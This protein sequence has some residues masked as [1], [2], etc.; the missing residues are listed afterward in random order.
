MSIL[1]P[2]RFVKIFALAPAL[3]A[4]I[5]A[6]LVGQSL[7]VGGAAPLV[8]LSGLGIVLAAGDSIAL[9]HQRVLG[10]AW[11]GLLHRAGGVRAA[12][13]RA[14]PWA[15]GTDLHIAQP[16][17]AMGEFFAD[18]LSAPHRPKARHRHRRSAHRGS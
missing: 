15:L 8:V 12:P 16:A 10:F 7:P 5:C 18:K 11:S 9:Y 14:L 13:D 17:N 6:V 1:S 4:T 2:R 3:L